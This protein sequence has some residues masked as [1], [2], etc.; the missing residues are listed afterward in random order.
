[1][2]RPEKFFVTQATAFRKPLED[3]I[4][5]FFDLPAPSLDNIPWQRSEALLSRR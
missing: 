5:V 3:L 4:V 1:V 2:S